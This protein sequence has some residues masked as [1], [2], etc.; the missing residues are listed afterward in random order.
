MYAHTH[1]QWNIT[2]SLKKKKERMPF[3][4]T[5]VDLEIIILSKF[6]ERQIPNDT[7]YIWN[8]KSDTNELIY[9]TEIDSD[10]ENKLM[11]TKRESG[12]IIH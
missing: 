6:R 3:A 10:T 4:G 1:T 2:Q 9:K 7:T 12:E 11:V 8:L 5:W